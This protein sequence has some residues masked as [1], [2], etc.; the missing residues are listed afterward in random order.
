MKED[1]KINRKRSWN[2]GHG[3]TLGM[4]GFIAFLAFMVYKAMSLPTNLVRED[5]YLAE[6]DFGDQMAAESRGN[7][8]ANPVLSFEN[9][10]L[11]ARYPSMDLPDILVADLSL[12]CPADLTKDREWLATKSTLSGDG[13]VSLQVPLAQPPSGLAYIEIEWTT[14]E[15]KAY[16]R[17]VHH[18][19]VRH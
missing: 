11:T 7:L 16:H 9:G 15:G 2:W 6:M 19:P 14:P 12:Y 18:F 1:Q 8:Y 13:S 4:L 3:L 5:Y 17:V 10:M